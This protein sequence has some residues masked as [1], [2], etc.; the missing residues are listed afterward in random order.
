MLLFQPETP[1]SNGNNNN[2]NSN[3]ELIDTSFMTPTQVL[4]PV[5]PRVSQNM[6][7]DNS[8]AA[9]TGASPAPRPGELLLPANGAHPPPPVPPRSPLLQQKLKESVVPG[10]SDL[11]EFQKSPRV[12]AKS[13]S[14][15]L[16]DTS[17]QY[18]GPPRD[19][20]EIEQ[21]EL[22]FEKEIASGTFGSVWKGQYQRTPCAIKKLHGEKLSQKQLQVGI[23]KKKK[24]KK[25]LICWLRSQSGV[26]G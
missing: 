25:N 13:A 12:P 8:P 21:D 20:W 1:K 6:Q 5:P 9:F 16:L 7:Q 11:L 14:D 4:P 10:G 15:A 17:G 18:T 2:N 26:S 19:E 23:K 22:V 3:K 24:K